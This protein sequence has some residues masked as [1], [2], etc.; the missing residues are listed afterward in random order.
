VLKL[1]KNH[2]SAKRLKYINV[3]NVHKTE[4]R[5]DSCDNHVSCVQKCLIG[6]YAV[7]LWLNSLMMFPCGPKHVGM[8]SVILYHKYLCNKFV[9]FVGLM[10]WICYYKCTEWTMKNLPFL[11]YTL[12]CVLYCTTVKMK[13]DLIQRF[14][15][16]CSAGI[17]W[18]VY[19][20]TDRWH[21]VCEPCRK[22]WMTARNMIQR[23]RI[24]DFCSEQWKISMLNKQ[25]QCHQDHLFCLKGVNERRF[26][27]YLF[28]KHY[29]C[30]DACTVHFVQF[31]IQ[32]NR[33]TTYIFI[34]IS[35]IH[36][37]EENIWT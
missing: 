33:C 10:S 4:T 28:G 29:P 20:R 23:E 34:Y 21:K 31:I 30:F 7:L 3:Q 13:R 35:T 27:P 2:S 5:N 6:F 19:K 11:F 18:S 37:V 15:S 32:T 14:R 16:H 9:H 17:W 1:K 25:M 26:P 36:G 24:A 22:L 12:H 8:I